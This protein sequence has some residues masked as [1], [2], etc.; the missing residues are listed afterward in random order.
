LPIGLCLA[1]VEDC[2]PSIKGDFEA[3]LRPVAVETSSAIDDSDLYIAS[4]CES[5]GVSA[6]KECRVDKDYF[7]DRGIDMAVA[8]RSC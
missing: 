4:L 1:L 6:D 5:F 7:S 2:C 3:I 8:S